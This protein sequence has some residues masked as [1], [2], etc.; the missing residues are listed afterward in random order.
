MAF[1]ILSESKS[2]SNFL[3]FLMFVSQS[4][5]LPFAPIF[6]SSYCLI[7]PLIILQNISS[8]HLAQFCSIRSSLSLKW[9]LSNW[10]NL[11]STINCRT[12]SRKEKKAQVRKKGKLGP[13][14]GKIWERSARQ[15][16]LFC[17][18]SLYL[19]SPGT[20]FVWPVHPP[21]WSTHASKLYMYIVTW[22]GVHTFHMPHWIFRPTCNGQGFRSW[23]LHTFPSIWL[24]FTHSQS[25]CLFCRQCC[26]FSTFS[27][28]SRHAASP[29]QM[30]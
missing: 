18:I 30:F 6:A 11:C 16:L 27:L 22:L 13:V 4:V 19:W 20:T 25:L 26:I 14:L 5:F 9:R 1:F 2:K 7:S 28:C 24:P 17:S 15:L 8:H 23:I 12:Q 3:L 10:P 29:L 21:L